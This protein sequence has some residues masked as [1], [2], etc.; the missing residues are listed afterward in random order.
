[1]RHAGRWQSPASGR[2]P[3]WWRTRRG[4]VLWPFAIGLAFCALGLWAGLT[5]RHNQAAFRA[6]AVPARAVIDQIY[7]SAP[8]QNYDAPTFS[9][10]A[11]V[12]FQVQGRTAHARVLLADNCRGT[13]IPEYRVGQVLTVEYSPENLSYARLPYRAS[14]ISPDF[15]Y[16]L[17][18][19]G[20]MAV[21]FLAAAVINMVTA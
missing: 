17:L 9:Q 16:A 5:Y 20:L 1:M 2:A 21:M 14:G 13:C 4:R 6:H 15:L 11:L 3:R 8:S 7:A 19:F 12:H 10:Y 18:A